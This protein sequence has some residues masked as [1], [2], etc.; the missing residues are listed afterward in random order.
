[1][2]RSL[3]FVLLLL[4]SACASHG[5]TEE[6]F[7]AQV[8]HWVGLPVMKAVDQWGPPTSSTPISGTTLYTWTYTRSGPVVVS[9]GLAPGSA[10]AFQVSSSCQVTLVADQGGTVVSTQVR[11]A[12]S[13]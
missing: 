3:T 11:G 8:S 2:N 9:P 10:E 12:C 7:R 13:S 4:V 1:M 6:S 5:Y